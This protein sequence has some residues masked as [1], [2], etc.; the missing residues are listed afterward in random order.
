MMYVTLPSEIT[1]DTELKFNLEKW[2][3][4]VN[5]VWTEMTLSGILLYKICPPNTIVTHIFPL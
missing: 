4:K 5:L 2:H 3:K 1:S